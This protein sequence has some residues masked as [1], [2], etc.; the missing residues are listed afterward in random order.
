MHDVKANLVHRC[1]IIAPCSSRWTSATP[2]RT[3]APF[4][5]SG[6]HNAWVPVVIEVNGASLL[7]GKQDPKLPV[8]IYVYALD[9]NGSVQDFVT[10][11][12]Q[13][14]LGRKPRP[15]KGTG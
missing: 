3:S 11:A 5:A 1:S 13:E 7:A 6:D 8:E 10:Q 4:A 14:K 15:K 12:I 2:R 9:Q